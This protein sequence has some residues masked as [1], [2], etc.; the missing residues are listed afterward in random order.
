MQDESQKMSNHTLRNHWKKVLKQVDVK[1]RIHD[2]RH[3][4]GGTLVSNGKTLEHVASVLG[5]TSIAV[6]KRYS[7]VRQEVAAESLDDFFSRVRG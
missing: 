5:H 4:I 7:K 1:L 3:I 2:L 6:T